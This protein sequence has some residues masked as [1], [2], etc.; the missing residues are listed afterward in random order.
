MSVDGI[1][2]L[3]I[4]QG[5]CHNYLPMWMDDGNMVLLLHKLLKIRIR[6]GFTDNLRTSP[7]RRASANS[8]KKLHC[9]QGSEISAMDRHKSKLM[10]A[11]VSRNFNV[12]FEI[13]FVTLPGLAHLAHCWVQFFPR[14]VCWQE[15]ESRI[16]HIDFAPHTLL[17]NLMSH[18]STETHL[19]EKVKPTSAAYTTDCPSGS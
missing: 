8:S 1:T 10:G 5:D 19:Y 14:K 6:N 9:S 16:F 2:Q 15:N 4:S 3:W 18:H 17:Q 7:K 13:R 12:G 11:W